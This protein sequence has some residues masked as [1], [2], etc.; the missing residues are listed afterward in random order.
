MWESGMHQATNFIASRVWHYFW[1]VANMEYHNDI[2]ISQTWW[3][4]YD[5]WIISIICKKGNDEWHEN[6]S[7]WYRPRQLRNWHSRMECLHMQRLKVQNRGLVEPR[8]MRLMFTPHV[9]VASRRMSMPCHLC[10]ISHYCLL[11]Y[12]C[13]CTSVQTKHLSLPEIITQWLTTKSWHQPS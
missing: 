1:V 7:P 3:M 5:A 11:Q 12:L 9:M 8:V 6:N 4:L 10:R 13:Y 2:F